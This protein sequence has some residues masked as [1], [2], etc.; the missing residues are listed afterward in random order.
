MFIIAFL[1]LFLNTAYSDGHD[2]RANII[3]EL[4][5]L[6]INLKI[7]GSESY[8]EI[9]KNVHRI[10]LD[11]IKA[12]N[13]A[14]RQNLI[15]KFN[16]EIQKICAKDAFLCTSLENKTIADSI[17]V[18]DVEKLEDHEEK[19]R[20]EVDEKLLREA[21]KR[22]Q[23]ADQFLM[24]SYRQEYADLELL[25][26]NSKDKDLIV[27]ARKRLVELKLKIG[28]TSTETKFIQDDP[29]LFTRVKIYSYEG[30]IKFYT[31]SKKENPKTPQF[32]IYLSPTC[33]PQFIIANGVPI[34]EK[35]C[36]QQN[37]FEETYGCGVLGYTV[38]KVESKIPWDFR[39]KADQKNLAN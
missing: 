15:A 7:Q 32:S 39:V 23:E 16:N 10:Q 34:T 36:I 19:K 17:F 18:F 9:G 37:N 11:Y 8:K 33:K 29:D 22:R 28:E 30:A 2:C 6:G 27:K 13:P 26:K 5:S 24:Q 12:K 14:T 31:V 4:R 20:R 35:K 21:I 3:S 38:K 1:T 25:A